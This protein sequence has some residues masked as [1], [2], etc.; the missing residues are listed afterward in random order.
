MWDIRDYRQIQIKER[1]SMEMFC[2]GIFA[3]MILAVIFIAGGAVYA[4]NTER[5]NDVDSDCRVYV[6]SRDRDRSG[7]QRDN[8][9]MVE[10]ALTVLEYFR[11]G[12]CRY[13]LEAIDWLEDKLNTDKEEA[14]YPLGRNDYQE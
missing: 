13:E 8:K 11:V 5:T 10:Q 3:G 12:A 2:F 14:E 9:R 4:R 6:P 7:N 1:G